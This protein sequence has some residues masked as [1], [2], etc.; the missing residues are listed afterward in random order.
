MTTANTESTK[1]PRLRSA[2]NSKIPLASKI[3]DQD[4]FEEAVAMLQ[5][6]TNLK[7]KISELE[8]EA[9]E[10]K[11]SLAAIC[12]AYSLPGIRHGLN[13]FEYYGYTTRKT[14]SKERL[15][16]LGVTAEQIA[17]SYVD[18]K[19]FLNAKINPFDLD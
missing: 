11:E 14:L 8:E 10:L 1:A 5:T 17:E 3:S 16:A 15:L 9:A 6:A 13:C 7:V 18:S 2:S 19:P 12:E 4:T